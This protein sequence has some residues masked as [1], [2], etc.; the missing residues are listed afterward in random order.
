M[1][2]SRRARSEDGKAPRR[3]DLLP[4]RPLDLSAE[5]NAELRSWADQ[6]RRLVE[7]GSNLSHG[8][9][10]GDGEGLRKN[11]GPN[12]SARVSIYRL[13]SEEGVLHRVVTSGFLATN[14]RTQS[15]LGGPG[16]VGLAA[17]RGRAL[18]A[19][20]VHADWDCAQRPREDQSEYAVPLMV[21]S[22][23]LGVMDIESDRAGGIK[24]ET[25]DFLAESAKA[26]ALALDRSQEIA[27]L[28]ASEGRLR[29]IFE[30]A[31]ISMGLLSPEGAI[32]FVNPSFARLLG[33]NPEELSGR[34]LMDFIVA[35]DA[36][37]V[38]AWLARVCDG[39]QASSMS[40]CRLL[41][42]SGAAVWAMMTI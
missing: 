20:D 13:H 28:Q 29:S 24:P 35:E 11:E 7:G 2:T 32:L 36:E 33:S 3:A 18:D 40:E 16:L 17:G 21:G 37:P 4:T 22:R 12:G 15:P 10:G 1:A 8:A 42:T 9:S 26:M 27:K 41:H 34:R 23:V 19:A 14:S 31:S 30:R 5:S 25:R 38:A 6:I 39:S